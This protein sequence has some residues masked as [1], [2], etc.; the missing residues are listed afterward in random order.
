M[1]LGA[2]RSEVLQ[3][4]LREGVFLTN[5]GIGIGFVAVLAAGRILESQLFKVSPFDPLTLSMT[6]VVLLASVD[7][8][9]LPSRTPRHQD[10]SRGG[11][12]EQL[13]P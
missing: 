3:S 8:G 9:L 6:S 12:S 5:A 1:A 2:Q 11:A 4:V 7:A 13:S 10:R